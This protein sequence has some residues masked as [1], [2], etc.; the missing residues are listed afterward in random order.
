[1][2]P[3]LDE[4][5]LNRIRCYRR[6]LKRPNEN[7]PGGEALMQPALAKRTVLGNKSHGIHTCTITSG[8]LGA[9]CDDGDA[10]QH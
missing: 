3:H 6:V 7:M 8:Y 1:M 2:A 4:E 5:L 10:G 9:I